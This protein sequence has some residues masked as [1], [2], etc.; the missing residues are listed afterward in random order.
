MERD[1]HFVQAFQARGQHDVLLVQQPDRRD[2]VLLRS[3]EDEVSNLSSLRRARFV[4]CRVVGGGSVQRSEDVK[5]GEFAE[6][7]REA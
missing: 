5:E 1:L 3:W 4:L 7:C 6:E 2:E